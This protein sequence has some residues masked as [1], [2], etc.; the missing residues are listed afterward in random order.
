M[1]PCD[2]SKYKC[3]NIVPSSCVPYTGP[4]LTILADPT[5]L[6]CNANINDVFT[7]FDT[8]VKGIL[9][10]IDLTGL[11]P[12]CLTFTPATVTMA[13]LS[14]VQIDKICSLDSQV[15][16]LTTLINDL[17]IGSEQITIDLLCLTP[18]AAACQTAANTYSLL[19]VLNTMLNEIC[20]LKTA[21]GI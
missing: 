20:A 13:Q 4:D 2:T 21:V 12:R 5:T 7:I 10:G 19:A 16:T 11:N 14:Q 8:T 6:A 1:Q 18:A 3:G 15:T 9:T 17:D